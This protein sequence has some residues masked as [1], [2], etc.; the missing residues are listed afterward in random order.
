MPRNT[1]P[2]AND[3]QEN[4]LPQA[5]R[6]VVLYN[7]STGAIFAIHYFGAADGVDLPEDD[8]LEQV[9]LS[10]AAKDGCDARTHKALHVDPTSLRRGVSYRVSIAKRTLA[11]VKARGKGPAKL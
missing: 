11:E 3:R 4:G 1:T 9:A 7:K 8:E 6:A 5:A 10:N 2:S